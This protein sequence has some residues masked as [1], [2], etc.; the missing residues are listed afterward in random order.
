MRPV[1]R[2]LLFIGAFYSFSLQAQTAHESIVRIKIINEAKEPLAFATVVVLNVPDTIH[3]QQQLTDSNGMAILKLVPMR[4]YIFRITSVNHQPIE[5]NITVK[6]ENATYTFVAKN[7]SQKLSEVVVTAKKPLMR[8]EDDKTIVEPENLALASTNAYEMME[9]VPGLFVDQDGNIF[10]NSTT[11]AKVYINGREQK[12]STADIATMLKSLPPN[13]IASIEII[14]TPS[15]KYDAST[16]GGIVNIV[17]KKG[18]KI[19][20]T[21]SVNAGMNQG[22]YGNQFAGINL[23][24]SNGGNTG[25]LN[26]QVSKRNTYEEITTDRYFTPDSILRQDAFTKYPANSFYLGYGLGYEFKKKWEFNYDGRFTYN[27]NNNSGYNT[28]DIMPANTEQ[29]VSTNKAET[30][31][32]LNSLNIAQ[33]VTLRKKIDSIGSDWTTDLSANFSPNNTDQH[34]LSTYLIPAKPATLA[35]GQIKNNSNYFTFQTNLTKKYSNGVTLETGLK[36]TW[37]NFHNTT[38][39]F[40]VT[41]TGNVRDVIR[42]GEYS[43]NENINSAYLQ[44]SKNFSGFILKIGTRLENTNMDGNQ[45]APFDTSFTIHRTD[46]FPYAYLSHSVMKIFGYELRAYLVYRRTINRPSYDY[47]NPAIRIVD[48]YLYETGNPSLRPQFNNNYEANISVE[49]RPIIAVGI[50][51]TKDIFTQVVY[52]ADSNDRITYRTWD[53][54]GK[55]KEFYMRGFG[56]IPPGGRYFF[57]LGGQYN[58]NFYQGQYE[59]APL[60]YKRGSWTFFTYHSFKLT[61]LTVLTLNG[62]VRLNGQ[63]QFY[64]LTPFG[65][66]NF[67]V[68]QQF[69]KKK[70]VVSASMV[71]MFYT[72]KND[73]TINQGSVHASGSRNA[74]TRR[75][76]L[77]LRYNFGIRKKEENNMPT[78]VVVPE[79]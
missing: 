77:N 44:G 54:L 57:V 49:E 55:N 73:F 48:P 61:P 71:D 28:S 11:P 74:D 22:I 65:S 31:N 63:F 72:N 35:N 37:L 67:S 50:N 3:K 5:K 62:F 66:L 1:I 19:G 38:D 42:T 8:Q 29:I 69:L 45:D 40:F 13:S 79:R 47:L 58:H 46:L 33:S 17:L 59:N 4:P 30:K 34:L 12:M 2:L 21:G 56:A 9:K 52:Q 76:G 26:L 16:S 75:F 18:V 51:E 14:R 15:A 70:L 39:Y 53:N 36:S 25:Y 7:I 60:D 78:D 41:D 27:Q 20:L 23:N 10:L 6:S 32:E 68:S 24:N 64:E 43:Y